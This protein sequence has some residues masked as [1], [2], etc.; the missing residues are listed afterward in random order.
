M[1]RLILG[2]VSLLIV[3]TVSFAANNIQRTPWLIDTATPTPIVT[4]Q[5]HVSSMRWVNVTTAGHKLIL[6]DH[7]TERGNGIRIAVGVL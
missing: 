4:G 3:S 7:R 1:V 5:I 2:L 6:V